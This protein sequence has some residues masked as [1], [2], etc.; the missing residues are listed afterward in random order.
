MPLSTKKTTGPKTHRIAITGKAG[1][2]KTSTILKLTKNPLIF[3]LEKK[4]PPE[5]EGF[6]DTW[7]FRGRETFHYLKQALVDL[8]NEAKV[9][10]DYVVVDSLS[11]LEE[12]CETWAIEQDY[13]RNKTKYSAY[14]TGAKHELPQYFSEI[15]DLLGRVQ[16]KHGMSVLCIGHATEKS[17]ANAMGKDYLK[18]VLDLKEAPGSRAL[19]WFDYIGFVYDDVV[20]D[21]T[22]LKGKAEKATRVISFDNQSPLFDGKSLK[23]LPTKMVFDKEGKW[24]DQVFRKDAIV[25]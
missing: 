8:L 14:S 19:K 2:G 21:E 23:V 25:K 9:T 11:K 10:Y 13:D 5:L 20:I 7:E 6:G 12:W 24:A 4:M 15:L 16:E 1:V 3:D 22:G 17:K 18:W